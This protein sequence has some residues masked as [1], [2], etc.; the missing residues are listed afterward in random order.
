[1]SAVPPGQ[2]IKLLSSQIPDFDGAE[3]DVDMWIERV[4]HIARIHGT[5]LDIALLA[6]PS[7]L[8]KL[9]RTWYQN[10]P[11]GVYES[12]NTFK[13]AI[14][15][16]FRRP[17]NSE[18]IREKARAR[19]WI[20]HKKSFE[21][22]AI[23]KQQILK[24]LQLSDYEMIR[25]LIMGIPNPSLRAIATTLPIVSVDQ[26]LADMHEITLAWRFE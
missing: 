19:E 8:I 5:S 18:R 17:I 7:K 9:A 4:E 21:V 14:I 6:A 10:V 20:Q 2:A 11:N 16:R 12:W 23:A 26:F 25:Q 3:Y 15:S 22:Y 1:M 13:E 24:R